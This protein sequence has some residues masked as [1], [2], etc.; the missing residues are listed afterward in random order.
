MRKGRDAANPG[1]RRQ[2]FY[3]TAVSASQDELFQLC[4]E[5]TVASATVQAGIH[6][7]V[8]TWS[9]TATLDSH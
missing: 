6:S 9:N 4:F 1:A 2:Y 3:F 7:R 5:L 8:H